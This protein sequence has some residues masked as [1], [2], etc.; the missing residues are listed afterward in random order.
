M[1][2]QAT[3]KKALP[4]GQILSLEILGYYRCRYIPYR[5]NIYDYVLHRLPWYDASGSW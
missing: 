1:K 3:A 4:P 2:N 5:R